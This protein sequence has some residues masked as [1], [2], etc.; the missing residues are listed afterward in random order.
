MKNYILISEQRKKM[1]L[2]QKQLAKMLGVQPSAISNYET[3]IRKPRGKTAI[4]LSKILQ[5]P[6]EKIIE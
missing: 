6:L 5:I 2:T 4:R 3:G 1:D